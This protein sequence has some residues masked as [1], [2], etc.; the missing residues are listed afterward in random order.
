MMQYSVNQITK[1][2][3][4]GLNGW[5]PSNTTEL[6]LLWTH[7]A[8]YCNC[9]YVRLISSIPNTRTAFRV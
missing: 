6:V 4:I 5:I 8:A 3:N 1:P 7:V 2:V 9:V